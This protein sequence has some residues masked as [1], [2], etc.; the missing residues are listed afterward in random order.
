VPNIQTVQPEPQPRPESITQNNISAPNQNP[1]LLSN[2]RRNIPQ[3]NP[4]F[5]RSIPPNI[6]S[7]RF[8]NFNGP[9]IPSIYTRTPVFLT[10]EFNME[11]GKTFKKAD[12]SDM[13]FPFTYTFLEF[14]HTN[15][16]VLDTSTNSVCYD[17]TL[18]FNTR[19]TVDTTTATTVRSFVNLSNSGN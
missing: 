14:Y 1:F 17:N 8:F 18:S 6:F 13:R 4:N 12:A 5:N 3:Q 15:T 10:G 19:T 7:G 11:I 2:P 9:S 16:A